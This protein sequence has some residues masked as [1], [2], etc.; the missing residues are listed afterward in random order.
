MSRKMR[1]VLT[2]YTSA[3]VVALS[4]FSYVSSRSNASLTRQA[5]HSASHAY[6]ETVA[7]VESMSRAFSKSIYAVDSSMCSSICAEAYAHALA[8]EAAISTLPFSTQELEKVSG[9]IGKAGDYAFT[10]CREAAAEGFTAEQTQLLTKLSSE[11]KKLSK[12]LSEMRLALNDGSLRLDSRQEQLSNV[13][14]PETARLSESLLEYEESLEELI[15]SYDGKHGKEAEDSEHEPVTEEDMLTQAAE[16]LGEDSAALRLEYEYAGEGLR[17][18][19][20]VGSRYIC[21]GPEGVESL[22]DSRLIGEKKLSH[23]EAEQAARDFLESRGFESLR[24]EDIKERGNSLLMSFATESSDVVCLNNTLSIA[25]ALDDGSVCAFNALSYR[26]GGA[27]QW[28]WAFSEEE[29]L[30]KLP[31]GLELS[32]LRKVCI[33]SPGGAALNCYELQCTN[34]EG[35]AVRIYIDGESGIQRDIVI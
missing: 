2:A 24:L 17:R 25:I 26:P 22:S 8:A 23:S 13:G 12:A 28:Q 9:F 4:V 27:Q 31:E 1:I 7:A 5:A 20:S 33:D 18:C 6:E 32:R 34:S 16:F 29:A 19:F 11:A 30:G 35:G 21:V 3:A 10:L 15:L 14:S